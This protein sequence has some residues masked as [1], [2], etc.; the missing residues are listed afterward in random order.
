M[1]LTVLN[2]LNKMSAKWHKLNQCE[3]GCS[4]SLIHRTGLN[5]L[6]VGVLNKEQEFL[7]Q[8]V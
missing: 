4:S 7:L 8:E 2:V 1:T 6:S 5:V 3:F